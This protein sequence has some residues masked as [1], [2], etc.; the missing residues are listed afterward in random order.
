[1]ERP[2]LS[3]EAWPCSKGQQGIPFQQLSSVSGRDLV[4]ILHHVKI[5]ALIP[6]FPWMGIQDMGII[7]LAQQ[8]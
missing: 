7:G 2:Y 4:R 6:L 1:M 3:E 8:E 5:S